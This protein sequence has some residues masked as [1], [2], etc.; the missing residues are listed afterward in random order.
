MFAAVTSWTKK[1]VGVSKWI[2]NNLWKL[3]KLA[4]RYLYT[5]LWLKTVPLI[6]IY[7]LYPNFVP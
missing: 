2:V 4:I 3:V 7:L 6:S 1:E 5:K